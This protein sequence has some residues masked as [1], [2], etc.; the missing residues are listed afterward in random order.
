MDALLPEDEGRV[1]FLF[2]KLYSKY[3]PREC[4][5]FLIKL[6]L[7]SYEKIQKINR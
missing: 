7:D 5:L 2:E 1:I 4:F 3:R 6:S